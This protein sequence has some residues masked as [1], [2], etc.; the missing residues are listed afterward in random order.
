[1]SKRRVNKEE[2]A[3]P[4]AEDKPKNAPKSNKWTD[5]GI[6]LI[7]SFVLI[8]AQFFL[9]AAGHYVLFCELMI[10]QI[11][12]FREIYNLSKEEEKEKTIGFGIKV[13]PYILLFTV[14]YFI[15]AKQVLHH[16]IS[17]TILNK[18][19]SLIC[20]AM[21]MIGLILFVIDLTPEN[22]VY[23]Y[24]RFSFGLC[25]SVV[26]GIAVNI[27]T[28]L[29]T[30]SI[31]WFFLPVAGVVFNDSLAYFCGRLFGRHPL[32]K[33]SPKKT[34]EGFIGALI[35]TPI[36]TFFIPQIFKSY[37][38]LYCPEAKPF[39]FKTTCVVPKEFIPT[40]YYIFGKTFELLPAQVHALFIGLFA[41][42]VAPFGG[43]FASGL[44]RS[45]GIKDFSNLI[46]GH[47]GI[48]DRIDCQIVMGPFVYLYYIT[49]V[50]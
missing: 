15:S 44:K 45:M 6:R 8:F 1:M 43:F 14:S 26:I 25:G 35:L 12:A 5:L 18:Y 4:Q 46:P 41:S 27:F 47:G 50:Q 17:D 37:P 39:D 42:L 3:V 7:S 49:F 30:K 24:K 9:F 22:D 31:F 13:F 34:I 16:F 48:L 10:L 36:C 29:A 33:L 11:L 38:F 23:A 20:F 21:L 19:H 32:I 2:K 28:K 40:T